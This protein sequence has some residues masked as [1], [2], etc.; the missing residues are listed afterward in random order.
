MSYFTRLTVF[1][2]RFEFALM[3]EQF[4]LLREACASL[5]ALPLEEL[6]IMFHGK[7]LSASLMH[8]SL[9]GLHD[10]DAFFSGLELPRLSKVALGFE[11]FVLMEEERSISS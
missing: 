3:V 2:L 1:E 7:G 8:A 5:S 6:E 9:G 4:V 10:V 11:F